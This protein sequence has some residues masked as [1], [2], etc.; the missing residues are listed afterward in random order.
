MFIPRDRPLYA[1]LST[2]FVAFDRLLADLCHKAFTGAVEL[3]ADEFQALL[4]VVDG[5]MA[6]AAAP[7]ATG[8]D[9]AKALT[10]RAAAPGG[11]VSVFAFEAPL[12]AAIVRSAGGEVLYHELPSAFVSLDRLLQRLECDAHS[13]CVEVNLAGADEAG[14]IYFERGLPVESVYHRDGAVLYGTDAADLIVEVSS[15]GAATF[16]VRRAH[17][18]PG[19]GQ[20]PPFDSR[21]ASAAQP[22]A[23]ASPTLSKPPET[24]AEV[25]KFWEEVIAGVE[26][27]VD[28]ISRP[29][30]FLLAF[31]EVLLA[32]AEQ[33]PFLDP[34][35]GEMEYRAGTL[36]FNAPPP[37][38]I[39]DALGECIED[40]IARLAF[41]LRRAD[42]ETRVRERHS[43]LEERHAATIERFHLGAATRAFVA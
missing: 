14:A 37:A 35:A 34:F 19:E 3:T 23:S 7:G 6:Y 43:G 11:L 36:T 41:Q 8:A 39:N 28:E 32:K 21:L 24:I 25:V 22:A 9:A 27:V 13:G 31:K 12:A 1:G 40:T 18:A 26:E 29:G 4:I 20:A 10:A 2:S 30:T 16:T 38:A 5:H 15:A 33:Q 42:L 17:A